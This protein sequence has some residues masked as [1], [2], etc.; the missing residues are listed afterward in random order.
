VEILL[1][2]AVAI[3]LYWLIGRWLSVDFYVYWAVF[4]VVVAGAIV[5]LCR[6]VMSRGVEQFESLA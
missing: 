4:L 3:F 2:N 5:G 6:S 1:F